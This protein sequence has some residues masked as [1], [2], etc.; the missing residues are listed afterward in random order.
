MAALVRTE[1][2]TK[3]YPL[4]GHTAA[5]LNGVSLSIESGEFVAVVGASGS[6]KSTFLNIIGFL[7]RPTTGRYWFEGLDV[8]DY[9]AD[10]LAD[11]RCLKLGFVFQTYNLLPRT[12]ALENVELPLIYAGVAKSKRRAV[13][14]GAL[15]RV[16]VEQLAGHTPNQLS[17]GQQ[18]RVAIARALVND[19]SLI[20]ADEPTGALDS[21][22]AN[23]VMRLMTQLNAESGISILLVTHEAFVAAYAH[24]I[25]TFRDGCVASDVPVGLAPVAAP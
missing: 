7:D 8:R 14:L 24:R 15:A 10:Q 18:Q 22:S 9:T 4:D 12:S 5:A 19:P 16:G 17:G 3:S 11:M 6:G 21:K 1:A 25:I 20:L 13:A 2:L 23:D